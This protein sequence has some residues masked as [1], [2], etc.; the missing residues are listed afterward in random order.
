MQSDDFKFFEEPIR[1]EIFTPLRME[2]HAESLA[3]AQ[4]IET[5]GRRGKSFRDRVRDNGRILEKSYKYLLQSAEENRAITPAADWLINNFHIVRTQLKDIHDH[6]PPKFYRELPKL[7]QGPFAGYPQVYGIAWAFVAHTDSRFDPDLLKKFLKSYQS[8]QVL[9]IGELWA[10]SITLRLVLME[11]LRRLSVRIVG[12][13]MARKEADQLADE[14]LALGPKSSSRSPSEI[15]KCLNKKPVI[16]NAFIVQLLQR[17]RFQDPLVE[18]VLLWLEGELAKK[19]LGPDEVAA[20]E[21]QSQLGA[22][23]T[24]RNIITSSRLISAFNWQEFFEEISLVD[25]VLRTYPL[26]EKMDFITRNRY[27]KALEDLAKRSTMSEIEVAQEIISLKQDPGYFLIDQGREV[28]EKKIGYKVSWVSY[29]LR[30]YIKGATGFYIS[31]I[32]GLTLIILFGLLPTQSFYILV[33]LGFFSASEIALTIVN[34]ITVALLGP[35]H[36]P[37]LSLREGLPVEA[38]TF[39]VIP[40]MFSNEAQAEEQINDLEIHYL[41]NPEKNMFFALLS[42][43]L[44]SS[45]ENLPKDSVILEHAEERITR[46]NDKYP[47]EDVVDRFYVFHRKRLFNPKENLWMGWERKRGKLE[48]FNAL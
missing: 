33:V 7:V 32:L 9:T 4:K 16:V 43:F 3:R 19:N 28:I 20:T 44:D 36:L 45:F 5:S 8:I 35:H 14:L 11:N 31:F 23:A 39:V 6:L 27:R 24:V 2:L 30:K 1:S 10:L 38:R 34:R 42:D 26:Y 41:S 25:D 29:F 21:H 46:L 13:Q 15:V 37:R 18:P 48:E 17:L 47:T 22:N 12:S 40:T